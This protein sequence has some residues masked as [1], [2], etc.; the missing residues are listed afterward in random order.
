MWVLR[1]LLALI[2]VF[3]HSDFFGITFMWWSGAVQLFFIISWFYMTLILREKYIGKES[4]KVFIQNRFL[5]IYPIFLST[6]F[7]T[8]CISILSGISLWN[9]WSFNSYISNLESL[10]LGSLLILFWTNIL[11]FGQDIIM[12]LWLNT[13]SAS[14]FFTSDFSKTS[15]QMHNFLFIP[16]AWSISIELMFYI[17]AP[18]LVRRKVHIILL[19][20]FCSLW[21]RLYIYYSLWWMNDPWTYRFFP[22]ELALFLFWT[23]AYEVYNYVKKNSLYIPYTRYIVTIFFLFIL[24]SELIK[25]IW[26]SHTSLNWLIYFFAII[27]IPFLFIKTKNSSFDRKL[28]DLSFP[29]YMVHILVINIISK[30]PY[31]SLLHKF[32]AIF[33]IWVSIALSILLIKY[34]DTPINNI[35]QK[36]AQQLL[37]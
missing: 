19:F 7:L 1:F 11:I 14:L 16:Q 9:W 17:I 13:E 6:L 31:P 12:F 32:D 25:Y 36:R 24:A 15:P 3:A 23:L 8:I 35:R 37:K 30:I 10:S 4:Y 29:I 20:I 26:F 28:W 18:L 5:R 27:W 2:V 21:L 33:V 34:I 22:T